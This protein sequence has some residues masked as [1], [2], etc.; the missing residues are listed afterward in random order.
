MS[1]LIKR[2]D[3]SYSKRGLWDNI[4]ANKGSGKKPTKE[5]LKQESKIKKEG[6]MNSM[7]KKGGKAS[8]KP[9]KKESFMEESKE[10]HFG[11]PGV[12]PPMK[13]KMM[14]GKYEMGGKKG[15]DGTYSSE[16]KARQSRASFENGGFGDGTTTKKNLLGQTVTTTRSGLDYDRTVTRKDGSVAKKSGVKTDAF[17]PETGTSDTDNFY[18]KKFDRSGNLKSSSATTNKYMQE[19]KD[20]DGRY[21]TAEPFSTSSKV[22]RAGDVTRLNGVKQRFESEDRVSINEPASGSTTRRDLKEKA[23]KSRASFKTG[24]KSMAPGGGGRFEALVNKLKSKGKSA[25]QAAG[26]A[27]SAGRAKYGKGK[28]QAMAAAGKKKG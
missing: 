24:G 21:T 5:M 26:I 2:K 7:Y 14:G 27:A 15:K 20:E 23:M 11:A 3:G 17:N 10:L 4:R 13:K 28:F 19:D 9:M 16:Q 25:D 8:K 22:N 12:R 18:K 6:S 1:K